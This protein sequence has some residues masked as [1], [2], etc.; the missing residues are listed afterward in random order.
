MLHIWNFYSDIDCAPLISGS[1]FYVQNVGSNIR[2]RC[3]D[4]REH[5]WPVFSYDGQR[6]GVS[7]SRRRRTGPFDF[8]FSIGVIQQV[9]NIRTV[10][11]VDGHAFT[12][13]NVPDHFFAADWIAAL[14]AINEKV[15]ETFDLQ[16][17]IRAQP[18]D[19]L[20]DGRD[21]RFFLWTLLF[22]ALR[23]EL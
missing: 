13:R 19:A 9:L 14:G 15:V 23:S 11:G 1:C 17:G 7:L 6:H 10:F 3:R 8:D 16:L 2:D 21:L 22:Q 5:T 20:H 4:L 18:E 12:A